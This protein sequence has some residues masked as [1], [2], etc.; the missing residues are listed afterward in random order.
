MKLVVCILMFVFINISASNSIIFAGD[1]L[2]CK[3]RQF[4]SSNVNWNG[5][6]CAF[7]LSTDDGHI[8]NLVWRDVFKEFGVRYTIFITTAWI[9]RL[10]KLTASDLNN[11]YIDGFEIAA[12]SVTHKP[13]NLGCPNDQN[14]CSKIDP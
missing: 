12:H 7:T 14:S 4:S 10:G 5:K 11:L 13:L 9:D 1:Q 8:D 6:S 2:F 3:N